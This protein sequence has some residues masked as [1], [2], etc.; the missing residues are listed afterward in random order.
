MC[1]THTRP[2]SS[3]SSRLGFLRSTSEEKRVNGRLGIGKPNKHQNIRK[4][5]SCFG[6]VVE[7]WATL[8]LWQRLLT[9]QINQ[10]GVVRLPSPP[11]PTSNSKPFWRKH[12]NNGKNLNKNLSSRPLWRVSFRQPFSFF[13]FPSST[14][15]LNFKTNKFHRWWRRRRL[16]FKFSIDSRET[17]DG[18]TWVCNF[19]RRPN[20]RKKKKK[21]EKDWRRFLW[22]EGVGGFVYDGG[23]LLL[24]LSKKRRYYYYYYYC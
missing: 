15:Q 20:P 10:P 19:L 1:V 18:V 23:P 16:V 14:H 6:A 13:F 11:P 21:R 8:F 22:L 24:L 9:R 4:H 2:S 3:S 5:S 17:P 7:R 12:A